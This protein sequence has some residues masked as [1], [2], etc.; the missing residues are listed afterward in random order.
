MA[1]EAALKA[2]VELLN[3]QGV[4]V[5][6][7]DLLAAL[8]TKKNWQTKVAALQALGSLK[9]RAPAQMSTCLP[10]IIP[11][12]TAIMSDAK[13]Q[14]KVIVFLV[15]STTLS[16]A[17]QEDSACDADFPSSLALVWAVACSMRMP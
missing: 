3:P 14:V 17:Y 2:F 11:A 15:A 9:G 1:A 5:V 10:N 16:G 13:P 7:P 8:D 4:K 6:L 12:M